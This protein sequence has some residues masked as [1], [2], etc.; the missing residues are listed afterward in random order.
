MLSNKKLSVGLGTF[1]MLLSQAQSV[2]LKNCL[3]HGGNNA[4]INLSFEVNLERLIKQASASLPEIEDESEAVIT[5]DEVIGEPPVVINQ[6]SEPAAEETN[7][8]TT[9]TSEITT[10]NT[11]STDNDTVE[12]TILDDIPVDPVT[13]ESNSDNT[14]GTSAESSQTETVTS[15]ETA[16]ATIIE[17]GESASVESES[18]TEG[19]ETST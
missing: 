9:T 12:I 6:P 15:S 10:T 3:G 7:S 5:G 16:T 14:G 13:G 17:G 1:T 19:P 18:S 4:D 11:S 8:V 2:N